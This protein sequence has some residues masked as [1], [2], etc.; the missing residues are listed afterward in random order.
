MGLQY[1]IHDHGYPTTKSEILLEPKP[2]I[3]KIT[4]KIFAQ[5]QR[6]STGQIYF[7][8]SADFQGNKYIEVQ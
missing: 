1:T 7:K 6:F 4:E 3:K 2:N 8:C 5:I